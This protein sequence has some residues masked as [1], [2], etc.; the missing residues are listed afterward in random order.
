M[1]IWGKKIK[2]FL[3]FL[4]GG[5]ILKIGAGSGRDAEIFVKAGYQY[6]G[7]DTSS[8]LLEIARKRIPGAVFLE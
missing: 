6:T 7:V 4:G 8:A 5:K 1:T 2:T 3:G